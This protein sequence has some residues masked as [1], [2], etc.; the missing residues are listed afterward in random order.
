M[1][2][3]K[4]GTFFGTS[5]IL[6][7]AWLPQTQS[8]GA[9]IRDPE[10]PLSFARQLKSEWMALQL[11]DLKLGERKLWCATTENYDQDRRWGICLPYCPWSLEHS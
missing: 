2:L 9:I 1:I 6:E 4:F 8:T 3:G 7:R 5:S 11:S 10:V